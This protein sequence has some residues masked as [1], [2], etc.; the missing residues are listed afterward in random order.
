MSEV[1]E[2]IR[3]LKTQAKNRRDLGRFQRAAALLDEAIAIARE[4]LK[5]TSV[6]EVRATLASEL[7]DCYGLLGGVERRWA[8]DPKSSPEER[9]Q[10]LR[11]SVDAYDEGYK[12]EA[13]PAFGLANTYNAV[14]RLLSR[15]LL[16]PGLLTSGGK[17]SRRE[18]SESVDVRADLEAVA[19][20]L[21]SQLA[22]Q[23]RGD[24]WALADLALI[25]VL[26]GKQD[27]A[28]AYAAFEA[29]LR[30]DSAYQSALAIV[31]P[32]AALDL[33]TAAELKLAGQ[34]LEK[35]LKSLQAR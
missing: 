14:N 16:D 11:R 13:D 5:T 19:R 18:G 22:T 17:G 15:L 7:A 29:E 30:P 35:E 21:Q 20:T 27:A 4:E 1:L 23:R 34:R 6:P 10:H 12:F 24:Y 2:R 31:K 33:P 26:L 32:L 3:E 28:S 9:A 8:L 25:N